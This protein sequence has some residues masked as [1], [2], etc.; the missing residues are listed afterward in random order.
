MIRQTDLTVNFAG[1]KLKNPVLTA[2]GTFGYGHEVSDL[3]SLSKLGGIITKTITLHPNNGNAQPRLYETDYGI[4][5]S[6][7][8][9]NIGLESFI[10][11]HLQK[12]YKIGV[13]IIVSIAGQATNE[14]IKIAKILS[15]HSIISAI[16]LNL[17]CPNLQKNIICSDLSMLQ[18]IVYNVKNVLNIPVIAKLSPLNAD[19]T[20]PAF[21]AQEAGADALTIANTYPAMAIDIDTYKPKL[22]T[23]KGGLSGPCIKPITLRCV[24]DV[25]KKSNIK[26]PIIGCGGISNGSDVIEFILA[27]ATAVS[28]G[29]V[30]LNSPSNLITIIDETYNILKRKNI[31][32]ITDLIGQIKS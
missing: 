10:Q 12:L 27:G 13:P 28:I 20:K 23:I 3:I 15:E 24:Y 4:L 25:Y 5:N 9:Q 22:S 16:E 26:I 11:N 8:L 1:I 32:S 29:S 2:S 30:S 14:Y 31:S 7:G 18:S 21:I 19:I 17:S 6:I